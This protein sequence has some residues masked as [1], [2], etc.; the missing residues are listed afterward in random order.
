MK[1]SLLTPNGRAAPLKVVYQDHSGAEGPMQHY[2]D[3][4]IKWSGLKLHIMAGIISL[5][6]YV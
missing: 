1:T 4:G 2:C 5:A 6:V 3:D